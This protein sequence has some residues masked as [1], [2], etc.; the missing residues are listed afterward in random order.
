MKIMQVIPAFSVGG[1][2]TMCEN[3]TYALREAGHDVLAVSLYDEH[4]LITERMESSGVALKY[5]AKKPGLDP[6]CVLRLR[7]LIRAYR[8]DVVHTHL[9]ALKYAALAKAFLRIR[10]VHTLHNVAEKEAS[11]KDRKLNRVFYHRGMAIPVS[12]SEEV[13]TTVLK[14]YGLRAEQSPV[15]YNGIDLRRCIPKEEHHAGEPFRIVH[16][17]RFMEQKNHPCMIEALAALPRGR[18]H[19][20]FLGDGELMQEIK[21]LAQKR[22]V[23]EEITFA[24]NCGDVPQ[25]LHKADVFILP[26]LW[27]GMPMSIIEAMGTA[28]PIIA[29]DVGGVSDMI[30]DGESGILI[31]P[32]AQELCAAIGR[33]AESE[34]L[35][36]TLGANAL[37][38]SEIFSSQKM[39]AAYL[40]IYGG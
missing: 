4:T 30:R 25:A 22:G 11:P 35:R 20:T 14:L 2:E 29:S 27:E 26:S 40:T 18:F 12:L 38:R 21:E 5:L 23:A 1:G 3:L 37:A 17:G 32:D 31:Q 24:G 28:L 33:V 6:G 8:P 39:A 36:D 15:I 16:V 9:Y 10:G 7:K 13:Q 34:A 19:L